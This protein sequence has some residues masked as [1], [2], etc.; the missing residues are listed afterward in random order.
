MIVGMALTGMMS[1]PRKH[2]ASVPPET[3]TVR[4]EVASITSTAAS[5]D[6]PAFTCEGRRQAAGGVLVAA[7]RGRLVEV[8]GGRRAV[9]VGGEEGGS[10]G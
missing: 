1:I 2:R 3:A 7:A 4:P 8:R 9:R 5:A 10:D 6:R